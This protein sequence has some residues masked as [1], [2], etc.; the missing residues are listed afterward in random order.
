M[1]MKK[2]SLNGLWQGRCSEKPELSFQGNVPGSV[3]DDLIQAGYTESDIFYR[4]NAETV[5]PFVQE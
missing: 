1:S 5:Q 3:L 4:A 2:I